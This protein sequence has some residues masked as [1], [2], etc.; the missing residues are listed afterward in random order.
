MNSK[1]AADWPDWRGQTAVIVATGPSAADA[2]LIEAKGL[3]RVIVIKSSWRLAPWADVLYGCDKGWWIESRCA[4]QFKGRKFSPSPTVCKVCRDV[5]LV[6]LI[7]KARI[8]TDEIGRIGCGL[9][10]G[11]GHSGF[12]A[13]N[14]AVQFGAK[15]IVLVGFDMRLDNGAHWHADA[16]QRRKNAK[17]VAEC[18]DALDACAPQ[19][20]ELGVEVINASDVSALSA[21]PKMSLMEA[22]GGT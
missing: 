19:F 12:H 15:R 10:T 9:R 7:A 3:A 18:R 2:P 21:Y 4:P 6:T 5:T 22:I 1:P 16:A 14:L 8:L 13:I 20:V 11:G 17:D